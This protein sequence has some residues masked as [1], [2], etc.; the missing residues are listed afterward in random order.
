MSETE[1]KNYI[2]EMK[3]KRSERKR[4][5][6]K[7]CRECDE[8][9][10]IKHFYKGGRDS[11]SYQSRC[12]PCHKAYTE[13]RR[14]MHLRFEDDARKKLGKPSRKEEVKSRRNGFKKLSKEDQDYVLKY[15]GTVPLTRIA[16][17]LNLNVHTMHG[18]KRKG[19]IC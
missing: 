1:I 15:F 2:D 19:L 18:W 6:R 9:K 8:I 10:E 5:T 11:R 14:Q 16:R 3:N 17:H 12:I 4:P 13:R 7:L